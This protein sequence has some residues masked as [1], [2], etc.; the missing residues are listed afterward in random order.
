MRDAEMLARIARF[1]AKLLY[2]ISHRAEQT[3]ADPTLLRAR[4][5]LVKVRSSSNLH[6][7]GSIMR[8]RNHGKS[9]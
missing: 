7:R 3:Q 9:H 2:L 1:G 8:G 4:D 5:I 6:V